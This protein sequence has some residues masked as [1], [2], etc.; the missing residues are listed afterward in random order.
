[1][2]VM[3]RVEF[4]RVVLQPSLTFA[5]FIHHRRY[6]LTSIAPCEVGSAASMTIR[7]TSVVKAVVLQVG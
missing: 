1:M 2:A 6:D 3:D 5:E 7:P 4:C